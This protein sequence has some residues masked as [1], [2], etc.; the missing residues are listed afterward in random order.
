[1]VLSHLTIVL[2]DPAGVKALLDRLRSSQS[3]QDV[4]TQNPATEPT[5]DSAGPS[6]SVSVASLLSQL[7]SSSSSVSLDS[8]NVNAGGSGQRQVTAVATVTAPIVSYSV[9]G[10]IP[11]QQDLRNLSFQKSLP[12]L[13]RLSEDTG[14]VAT[15]TE[16]K[17]KQDEL[18]RKLFEE[19][20]AIHQKY[21]DKVKLALTKAKM[22][23]S[24]ISKHEADMLSDAYARELSKFD[25]ERVLPA[26]DSMVTRQQEALTRLEVPTMFCTDVA[27]DREVNFELLLLFSHS[28]CNQCSGSKRSHLRRCH[29]S[30]FEKLI[31]P[32][33]FFN[34]SFK[35][36]GFS[37][38]HQGR[39]SLF[40]L[41]TTPFLMPFVDLDSSDDH[42]SIFYS[43]NTRFGNVGGFDPEKPTIVML[44]PTFM[45]STWVAHHF[46][47]PRLHDHY[48][49]IAFDLRVCGRST[50]RSSG[51][52]DSWTEAADLAHCFQALHLPTAH[53]LA[54]EGVSIFCALRFALLFPEMCASLTLCNV[55]TP[56]ELKWVF[57]AYDELLQSIGYA[58]DLESFEHSTMEAVR[59]VAGSDC[60]PDIQD[61]IIAFWQVHSYPRTRTRLM[62]LLSVVMNR[63]P[64]TT[65]MHEDIFQPVLI[66]HGDK[67]EVSPYRMAADLCNARGGAIVYPVKGKCGSSSLSIV[68]GHASIA[69]QVFCKFL[70]RQ[71]HIRSDIVPPKIPTPQR[72]TEA[73]A[74][75]ADYIGDPRIASRNPMSS[76]SFSC[77]ELAAV[78]NQTQSLKLYRKGELEAF[79][80]LGPDGKPIRRFSDRKQDHWFQSEKDGL[81]YAGKSYSFNQSKLSFSEQSLALPSESISIETAH[82]GRLRRATI[83]P[84]T[85]DKHIVKGSMQKV[86][87]SNNTTSLQRLINT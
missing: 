3:F 33:I 52:H 85:V 45:D 83:S 35:A 77:L 75:L 53:I 49:I 38:L 1:M 30:I 13:A 16:L 51:R 14:F 12:H 74:K 66:I 24:G 55:P 44:H 29:T 15:L 54:L 22:I 31:G 47:D 2:E 76:L 23:G 21:Q 57:T 46:N 11:V 72:M 32:S 42:A 60:D 58:T 68:P 36:C 65:R 27:S 78:Q 61:D 67:N 87:S 20:E 56:T 86:I 73:L 63:T 25:R 9:Q 26:W 84:T 62:E 34:I 80:P 79:S 70:S 81:S 71:P 6:T 69:T 50:C 19:R 43:T 28:S 5:V 4:V 64:L 8:L 37:Q 39:W 10:R 48:N 17:R 18:E 41:P 7:Q 40:L 82:Q 59:F